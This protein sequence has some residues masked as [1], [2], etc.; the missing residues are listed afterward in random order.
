MVSTA[1]IAGIL[2]LASLVVPWEAT[3]GSGCLA[4][5]WTAFGFGFCQSGG[6]YLYNL[7]QYLPPDAA[8]S[9]LLLVLVLIGALLLIIKQ[10]SPKIGASLLVVGIVVSIVDTICSELA[11]SAFLPIP[12]GF[13]LALVAGIIGFVAKSPGLAPTT[14]TGATSS[15]DKLI[16]LKGLLDS[17]AITREEF[18][19]QKK[20]ILRN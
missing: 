13:F 11:Y 1:R 18:E 2:A 7:T 9:A 12:M 10:D 3:Y 6:S 8:L 20:I 17:G 5:G 19:E 4:V 14:I 15:V 16:K